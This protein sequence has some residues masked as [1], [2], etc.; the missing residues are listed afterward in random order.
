MASANDSTTDGDQQVPDEEEA[1]KVKDIQSRYLRCPSPRWCIF[2]TSRTQHLHLQIRRLY[3]FYRM[4]PQRQMFL[5]SVLFQ[6]WCPPGGG[7][8][9]SLEQV[10]L[11]MIKNFKRHI[12]Q[13]AAALTC[14][15]DTHPPW[16]A[17]FDHLY[18]FP[19]PAFRWCPIGFRP[20]LTA[21]PWSQGQMRRVYLWTPFIYLQ[22]LLQN[23]SSVRVGPFCFRQE[24][25]K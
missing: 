2:L 12:T 13:M 15:N 25:H 22:L 16:S 20:S 3:Q 24:I 18:F 4:A 11:W 23:R 10:S 7:R 9:L 14:T 1:P 21:S 17:L 5:P 6:T 19:F 8:P